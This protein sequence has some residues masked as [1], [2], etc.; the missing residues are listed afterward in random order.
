MCCGQTAV[1]HANQ[2]LVFCSQLLCQGWSGQSLPVWLCLNTKV[3]RFLLAKQNIS[4]QQKAK[5]RQCSWTKTFL[6]SR[7][8]YAAE[9]QRSSRQV[10]LF[11]W[12]VAYTGQCNKVRST[13][14]KQEAFQTWGWSPDVI[15]RQRIASKRRNFPGL[16]VSIRNLHSVEV[17][18]AQKEWAAE[19]T[20]TST[21]TRARTTIATLTMTMTKTARW[22]MH[23]ALLSA[24]QPENVCVLS[25]PILDSIWLNQVNTNQ[26]EM[27]TENVL[28][29]ITIFLLHLSS[30]SL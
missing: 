19:S 14:G 17:I 9:S 11:P 4:F 26:A 27:K 13:V 16:S 8:K 28:T 7:G 23:A 2:L 30:F 29:A 24:A 25:W 6:A 3:Q 21:M 5:W 22:L 1:T 12:R 20:T 10:V 18:H 15:Q